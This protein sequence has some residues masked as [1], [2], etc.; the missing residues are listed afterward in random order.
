MCVYAAA[1]ISAALSLSRARSLC[2]SLSLSLA[3]ALSL[4]QTA[5]GHTYMRD[6]RDSKQ[7]PS[8]GFFFKTVRLP[9]P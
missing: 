4:S 8:T 1:L 5:V 9:K 3:R 6:T 2:L 7:M